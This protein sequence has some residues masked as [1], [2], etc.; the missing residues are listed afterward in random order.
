MYEYGNQKTFEQYR[1][2][3]K[4]WAKLY[5]LII[6]ICINYVWYSLYCRFGWLLIAG[7]SLSGVLALEWA[8]YNTQRIHRVD[9]ER[10]ACFPAFRR[11]E[12]KNW[13]KWLHYPLAI[14]ACIYKLVVTITICPGT[15][16]CARVVLFGYS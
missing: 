3:V 11:I 10:D 2:Q 5:T 8:W 4:F 1:K 16:T 14:T 7:Y 6:L 13:N 15:A 12:A 9:E